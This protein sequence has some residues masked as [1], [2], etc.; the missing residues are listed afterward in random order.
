MEAE[1][2]EEVLHYSLLQI[3]TTPMGTVVTCVANLWD[4]QYAS[5]SDPVLLNHEFEKAELEYGDYS[6]YY[7][8]YLKKSL[9]NKY[10]KSIDKDALD[11]TV[12]YKEKDIIDGKVFFNS[13]SHGVDDYYIYEY[14]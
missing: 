6:T 11:C 10:L 3:Y 1:T 8:V 5:K 2:K 13:R 12:Y 9:Y 14:N 4:N 7:F